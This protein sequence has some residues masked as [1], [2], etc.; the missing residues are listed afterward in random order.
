MNKSYN[1]RAKDLPLVKCMLLKIKKNILRI[2]NDS[3]FN[4]DT[5]F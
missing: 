5:L 2:L 1:L 4:N 3:L